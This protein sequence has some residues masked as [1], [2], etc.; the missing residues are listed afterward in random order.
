MTTPSEKGLERLIYQYSDSEKFR[1]FLTVFLE[2]ADDLAITNTQLLTERNINDAVGV[3]LDGIGEIVGLPRP[4]QLADTSGSFGF[5][6]DDTAVGFTSYYD[7]DLGGHFISI[8]ESG[9][10][11]GDDQYR[12]LLKAAVIK[13][14]TNMTVEKVIELL[15]FMFGGVTVRYIL[16]DTFQVEYHINT[17]ID[18]FDAVLFDM[19]PSLL[20]G[21][22]VLYI[23]YSEPSFSF[24]EDL[25]GYGFGDTNN[26]SVGGHFAKILGT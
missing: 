10:L 20:G 21:G 22:S 2:Q 11:I 14:Q 25:S 13:N 26:A 23:S 7:T 1:E 4:R 12:L 3:Q 15:S 9:T 5:Y 18:S 17:D 19:L 24:A 16:V 8:T 6:L